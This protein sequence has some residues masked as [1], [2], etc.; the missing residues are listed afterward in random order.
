MMR[1]WI[2]FACA[3]L[4]IGTIGTIG[5]IVLADEGMWLFN[6]PPTENIKA[7]YN[8]TVT[9][10]WLEHLQK[11]S[12]R[13]NSGGSGS[14]V[15]A[16]GLT[17]TNHHIAQTCLHGLSTAAHDLFKTGFYAKTPGDEARC[18][19][20]EL[21]VL[22]SADD[23]TGEI[24]LGLSPAT[25]AAEAGAKQRA[26]MSRV[27]SDCNKSTGL[28]CDVVTLYSGAV[29]QLYRYKKYTDVRLVFVP[30]FDIAFFGGDPDNFEFPR[31]DLDVAFFRIYENGRP[32]HLEHYLKWGTG[33]L[34]DDDLVFVSGHPG[35]T[36]RLAT[37]TQLGFLRDLSL[38]L[39]LEIGKRRDDVLKKWGARSAENYRRAQETIF[40]IENNLKRNKVYLSSLFD[41]KI[42]DR[43]QAEENRLKQAPVS[44]PRKAE[45]GDPWADIARAVGTERETYLPLL[46]IERRAGFAGDLAA[47][48]RTLVRVVADKQKPNS[49]R[50]REYNDAALPSL[51]Q[52]L[53]AS[54]P[55]YKDME[56]VLLADSL[57]ML[58]EKLPNG[59]TTGAV[60]EQR[61]PADVARG[62]VAG[63]R[64]DDPAV[65]KQLYD[66]GEAAIRNSTDPMIV[67]MRSID[68][69]A[70]KYR[71]Q[72]DDQVASVE[73]I[74]GG[75]IG[76]RRFDRDGFGVAPDATFT[77]RLSYGRVGG[78]VED[79]I[80]DAVPKGT[81]VA[82]FTNIG[83]AF[84][85]AAKM[86][87]K[88]PFRLPKSW[89]DARRA[90][91]LR[92]AT[93]LNFVSTADIIGGNSGSPV[94]NKAAEVVGIIF[95]GNMQSL[96]WRYVF[97]DAIGRAVSVDS[98]GI[99]EA[100]RN[101]YGAS[102]LADELASAAPSPRDN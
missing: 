85:R 49:A 24:N 68:A 54:D 26:N 37:M 76:R 51:E 9:P 38:P 101:I 89:L 70:R 90:G 22:M 80:G 43:K 57:A 34:K 62:L 23:V 63:T 27:E 46:M 87:S 73:R 96:P 91:K 10:A 42:M 19:D 72:Y 15:S 55:V 60:L 7:Q 98:R 6:H 33:D 97:D 29:Y 67:L 56:A 86:G 102:R 8:F 50:L 41:Q 32:V 28:R 65:R 79:G 3:S 71:T 12:V 16:D 21:N 4:I 52:S 30:E 36:D 69:E 95:D 88:D 81:K 74:A 35:S 1:R 53:F 5:T 48:A 58:K 61:A 78:Y 59:P 39:S 100:L 14:F 64:L 66:G 84:D 75:R 13:F 94:V 25:A 77:L 93:P 92:L 44:D 20:L 83:G 31:Y 18:P 47:Y 82:P 99:L 17:F 40:S 2:L 45:E 11:S